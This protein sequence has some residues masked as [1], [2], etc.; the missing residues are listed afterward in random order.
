MARIQLRDCIVR[1]KDGLAGV[2]EINGM[3]VMAGDTDLDIDGISLNTDDTDRV[4]IGARFTVQGET[5]GQVHTVTGRTGTPTTNIVFTPALGSGT[6]ADGNDLTFLPQQIEI[7]M[8][9]GNLTY[10]EN[11]EY[12]YEL[13][14]SRLDTVTKGDDQPMQVTIDSNYEAIT[15]GTS[16]VIVPMDALKRRGAASEWVSSATDKCEPYAVDIEVIH[17]PP[18]G[19]KQAERTIFPD[20]RSESREVNFQDSTISVSGRC[21]ATEPIVDR[22]DY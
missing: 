8:G 11:D 10:T 20:F 15:T 21:N 4:P 7:K 3:G 18:C 12:N 2:A 1:M 5:N 9:D 6:Y 16:E 13:D 22:G 19:T 17:R 14:R